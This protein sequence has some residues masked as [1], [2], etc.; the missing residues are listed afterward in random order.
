MDTKIKYSLDN[1]N[2]FKYYYKLEHLV[3]N[4]L[5][6]GYDQNTI[7]TQNGISTGITLGEAKGQ[8]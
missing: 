7:I 8:F 5:Q 6:E 3:N 4:A 2:Y 1:P